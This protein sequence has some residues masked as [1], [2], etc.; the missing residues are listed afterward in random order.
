MPLILG[1]V[2]GQLKRCSKKGFVGILVKVILIC[3]HAWI[4]DSVDFKFLHPVNDTQVEFVTDII[5]SDLRVWREELVGN[6]FMVEDV[7][8]ILRIPFARFPHKDELVWCGDRSGEFSVKEAYKLL[9]S[10]FP[11]L[12]S[13]NLHDPLRSIFGKLW[14]L[15]F[16]TK[17]KIMT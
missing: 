7:E 1:R 12:I 9:H 13:N 2:Y 8:C 10:T 4:P 11:S 5:N 14:K 15:N 16:P 3:E 6:T 17:I